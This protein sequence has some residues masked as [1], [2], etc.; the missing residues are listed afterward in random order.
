MLTTLIVTKEISIRIEQFDAFS[1]L[2]FAVLTPFYSRNL[3]FDT[4]SCLQPSQ[5]PSFARKL[6]WANCYRAKRP[7]TSVSNHD[8]EDGENVT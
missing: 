6:V 5:A 2:A 7:D 4:N 3:L 1:H 8:G